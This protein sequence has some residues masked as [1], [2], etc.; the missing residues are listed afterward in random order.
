MKSPRAQIRRSRGGFTLIELLIALTIAVIIA[1]SLYSTLYIAYKARNSAEK[2]LLPTEAAN[3]AL[4]M[5]RSDLEAAQPVRGTLGGP[6]TGTQNLN[7]NGSDSLIFYST[8]DA[9]LPQYSQGGGFGQGGSP[10]AQ[11]GQAGQGGSPFGQQSLY[12]Q[13]SVPEGQGEIKQVQLQVYQPQGSSDLCLVRDV[14][15]NLLADIQP[16]PDEEII[17]RHVV[18]FN[19]SYFDGTQWYETW[20][21]TQ[22]GNVIPYAVQVTLDVLP[23]GAAKGTKPIHFVRIFPLSCATQSTTATGTTGSTGSTGGTP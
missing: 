20:D 9:P 17:C 1:A 10:F 3:V 13:P 19:L 22:Q 5:I 18:A 16:E 7:G 2:A 12:G 15:S 8:A 11:G 6:F 21:S 4:D 14:I 23:P